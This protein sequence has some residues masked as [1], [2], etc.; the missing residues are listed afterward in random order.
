M[1]KYNL[2]LDDERTPKCVTWIEIPDVE[3]KVVRS[4]KD[5]TETIKKEGLPQI[6][7]LDHDLSNQHYQEFTRMV[8]ESNTTGN[9]PKIRYNLFSEKTGYDAAKWL[10]DYC[11]DHDLDL[12]EYI[13]HTMNPV[14]W[15][16][17]KSILDSYKKYRKNEW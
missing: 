5:F 13:V 12:P 15:A 9:E 7:S 3:W 11:I 6:V 1:R 2:F 16:N 4:Y 8:K 14:G 17:I 10:V